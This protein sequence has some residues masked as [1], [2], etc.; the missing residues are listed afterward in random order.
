VFRGGDSD[1]AEVI[2]GKV[3]VVDDGFGKEIDALVAEQIS[4]AWGNPDE[5]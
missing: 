2:D 3:R 1:I 5:T 4:K